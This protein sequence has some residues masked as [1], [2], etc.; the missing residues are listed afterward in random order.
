MCLLFCVRRW[1]H[2]VG[3]LECHKKTRQ[4]WCCLLNTFISSAGKW[5]FSQV[6]QVMS[7]SLIFDTGS[8]KE[9]LPRSTNHLGC[10]H[11]GRGFSG[12]QRIASLGSRWHFVDARCALD[13]LEP[14]TDALCFPWSTWGWHLKICSLVRGSCVW[15]SD[16]SRSIILWLKISQPWLDEHIERLS[17]H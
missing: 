11:P 10:S 7:L 14:V 3:G 2:L 16:A 17:P 6:N 1:S 4:F 13:R 5:P 8:E 9:R 15:N 12:P